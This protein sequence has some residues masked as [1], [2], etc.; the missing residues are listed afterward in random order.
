MDL[1]QYIL[2]RGADSLEW[3]V[4]TVCIALLAAFGLYLLVKLGTQLAR[5]WLRRKAARMAAVPSA[6]INSTLTAA[7]AAADHT[8]TFVAQQYTKAADNVMPAASHTFA[9]LS[10]T[11]S[12]VGAIAGDAVEAAAPIVKSLADKAGATGE[13][14]VSLARD[15]IVHAAPAITST[16]LSAASSLHSAATVIANRAVASA[17]TAMTALASARSATSDAA[18]HVLARI[19]A[20]TAPAEKTADEADPVKASPDQRQP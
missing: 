17:P 1:L 18:N 12:R 5:R 15:G 6:F 2:G 20:A 7:A 9:Q 10:V 14:A 3:V 4:S 19:H 16:A 13:T 8:G 11:A